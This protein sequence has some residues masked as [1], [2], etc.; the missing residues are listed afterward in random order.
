[1]HLDEV[2]GNI[3]NGE[4]ATDGGNAIRNGCEDVSVTNIG[5]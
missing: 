4:D 3:S 5:D 1:M 2:D